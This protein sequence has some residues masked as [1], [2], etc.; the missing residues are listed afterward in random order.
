MADPARIKPEESSEKEAF[1]SEEHL[2]TENEPVPE[3]SADDNKEPL[4]QD[5]LKDLKTVSLFT[6][7]IGIAIKHPSYRDERKRFK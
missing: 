1:T 4:T 2:K 5:R 6:P 3:T 7:N